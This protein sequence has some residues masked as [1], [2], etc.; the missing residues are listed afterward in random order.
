MGGQHRATSPALSLSSA[1]FILLPLV[2]PGTGPACAAHF[3]PRGDYV[4]GKYNTA[5]LVK[6][7]GGSDGRTEQEMPLSSQLGSGG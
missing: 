5:I 3:P 7:I 2:T 1:S 4:Q 6:N